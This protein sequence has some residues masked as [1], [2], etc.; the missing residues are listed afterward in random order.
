MLPRVMTYICVR[1]EDGKCVHVNATM[2]Y[3]GK[4]YEHD[5]PDWE[6][7]ED[8]PYEVRDMRKEVNNEDN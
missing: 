2:G 6:P 4:E 7:P 8:W 5:N 1:P 3:I